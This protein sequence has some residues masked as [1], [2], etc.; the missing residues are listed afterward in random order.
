M[1]NQKEVGKIKELPRKLLQEVAK[2]IVSYST[3]LIRV[4]TNSSGAESSTLIGSGTFVSISDTYGILTAAH[5]IDLLKGHF[6]LGLI[7]SNYEHKYTIKSEYLSVIRIAKGHVDSHGPD[8]GF[9]VLPS[10]EIG[11]I[12]A[13]KGFCNLDIKRDKMLANPPRLDEGFWVLYGVPDIKTIDKPTAKS[14][15]LIKEY[16]TFC[17]FGGIRNLFIVDEFD[18]CNF[19]VKYDSISNIPETFGG[20]SGGGLWQVPLLKSSEN[21]IEP[22]EYILSGV[23]FYQTERAGLNRSIKCHCRNS[24]YDKAYSF[25]AENR[26][27]KTENK[28]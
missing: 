26:K 12:R 1:S 5:V 2:I 27:Q 6:S 18:Y 23:V 9:I 4:T 8:L 21:I 17:F 24:I 10:S 13:K 25:I 15:E 22:Q 16:N 19:E 7:L 14:F 3:G 20:F 28:Q 11:T